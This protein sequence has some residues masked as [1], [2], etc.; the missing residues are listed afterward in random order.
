MEEKTILGWFGEDPFEA[1]RTLMEQSVSGSS[2]AR[3]IL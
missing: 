2:G 1:G 3:R